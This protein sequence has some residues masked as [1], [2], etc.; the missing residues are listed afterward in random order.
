ALTRRRVGYKQVGEQIADPHAESE[1]ESDG[2]PDRRPAQQLEPLGAHRIQD[3]PPDSVPV[4]SMKTSSSDRWPRPRISSMGPPATPWPLLTPR[5]GVQPC[6][7]PLG[8]GRARSPLP[9]PWPTRVISP[10]KPAMPW[11][12]S[13]LLGSSRIRRDGSLSRAAATPSRCFMPV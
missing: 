1:Q 3:H 9:P 2:H 4:N 5:A 7:T 11:G 6:S 12:S 8:G 10:R 13:P